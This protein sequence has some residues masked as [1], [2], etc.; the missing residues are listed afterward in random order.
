MNLALFVSGGLG[1]KLLNHLKESKHLI[2]CVYTDSNSNEII[3]TA[4]DNHLPIFTGNPRNEG[5]LKFIDAF[6]IDI[7]LSVNYLFLIERSL[8]SKAKLAVNIH[9]SLLPKYRGRTPHVWAIIN[10]EPKTG[11]TAH[12]I[13]DGCDTGDIVKQKE[14][15]I[16]HTD[17][18]ADILEKF[19]K[20]Y[21]PLVDE[22]LSDFERGNI[23]PIPQ[24]Y[25]NATFFGKRTPDDGRINWGWQTERIRNWVRAQ[26]YPYPGA[27][28]Y[29]KGLDEKVII[30]EVIFSDRGFNETDRNGLIVSLNPICVKTPNGVLELRNI[31]NLENLSVLEVG[32]KFV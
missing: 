24:N 5:A 28:T 11:V 21:V 29:F 23:K 27:F 8:F 22:I 16:D 15:I 25:M 19:N 32:Q 12:L 13:D 20:L 3:D 10:N 18:G 9:G 4:N 31:R 14:V 2:K 6:A 7:I 26:A 30:D 1:F 17:T